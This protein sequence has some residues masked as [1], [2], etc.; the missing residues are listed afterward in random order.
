MSGPAPKWYRKFNT[1][2]GNT[3][4][5]ALALLLVLGYSEDSRLLLIIKLCSSFIRGQL[6][7]WLTGGEEYA[8]AGASEALVNLTGQTP[9]EA[10]KDNAPIQAEIVASKNGSSN[11][12]KP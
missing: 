11:N 6:S 8:P 3:E 10:I 5:F 4:T 12:E 7:V 1:I 2:Y 9:K